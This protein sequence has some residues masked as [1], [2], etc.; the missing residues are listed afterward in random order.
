[1]G[2]SFSTATPVNVNDLVQVSENPV[3]TECAVLTRRA[4]IRQGTVST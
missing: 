3:G 4:L 1:L 2:G